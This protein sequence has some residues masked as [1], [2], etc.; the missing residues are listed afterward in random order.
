MLWSAE[1]YGGLASARPAAKIFH[2]CCNALQIFVDNNPCGNRIPANTT[3]PCQAAQTTVEGWSAAG[4]K[5]GTRSSRALGVIL[6]LSAV[7]LSAQR[8]QAQVRTTARNGER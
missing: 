8:I 7:S 5:V 3:C 2:R 6:L 4:G 1:R